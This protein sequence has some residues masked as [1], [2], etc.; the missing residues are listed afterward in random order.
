MFSPNARRILTYLRPQRRRLCAIALLGF[1]YIPLSLVEPYLLYYLTDRVLLAGR[2]DLLLPFFIRIVPYFVLA[3]STEF[4]LTYTL[5]SMARDLHH[6]VKSEQ[7]DNLLAKGANFFR[8]T[9][10]GKILFS[11]FNDSNQIGALLGIGAVNAVL[12]LFF[13]AARLGLL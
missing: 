5:L 7:L 13:V 2:T 12:N 11:F 1:I 9:A 8:N 10:S 3:M 4:L 6:G